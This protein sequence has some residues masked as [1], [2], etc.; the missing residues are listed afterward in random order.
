MSDDVYISHTFN[1]LHGHDGRSHWDQVVTVM[2]NDLRHHLGRIAEPGR[3]FYDT[4]GYIDQVVAFATATFHVAKLAVA[5]RRLKDYYVQHQ[6]RTW[7]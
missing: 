4:A 7:V 6:I 1:A 2:A 3:Q 5:N